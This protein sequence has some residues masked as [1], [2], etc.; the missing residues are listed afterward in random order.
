VRVHP[1]AARGQQDRSR[2]PVVDCP[3][4]GTAQRWGKR[5]EDDFAALA[6]HAENPVAVLFGEVVDVAASG[7]EDAKA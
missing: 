1:R 2:G 3:V 4:D 7:L 6:V 5:D